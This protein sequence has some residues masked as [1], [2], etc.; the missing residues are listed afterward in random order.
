[1]MD[2]DMLL[3]SVQYADVESFR[4]T[5]ERATGYSHQGSSTLAI[6]QGLDAHAMLFNTQG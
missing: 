4:C 3:E 2:R 1:M 6:W 5:K